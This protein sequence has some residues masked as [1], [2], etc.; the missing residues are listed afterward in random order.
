MNK[1]TKEN[2]FLIGEWLYRT[3][4][5]AKGPCNERLTI[6]DNMFYLAAALDDKYRMRLF[7]RQGTKVTFST[8][9]K[10]GSN[11]GS[12]SA[13]ENLEFTGIYT[14]DYTQIGN[15][16][17]YYILKEKPEN[18]FKVKCFKPVEELKSISIEKLAELYNGNIFDDLKEAEKWYQRRFGS[19]G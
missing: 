17:A 1:L 8:P 4:Y 6:A 2:L 15:W 13:N 18:K 16:N 19:R 12:N 3:Q 7:L 5:L 11:I 10:K 14:V 9:D